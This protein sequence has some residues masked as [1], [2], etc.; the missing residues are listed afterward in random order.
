MQNAKTK[1]NVVELFKVFMALV[2]MWIWKKLL[3]AVGCG[4]DVMG[5]E[6]WKS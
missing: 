2:E 3:L 6:V 5:S 1:G 4:K